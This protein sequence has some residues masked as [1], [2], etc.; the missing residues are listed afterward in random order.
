MRSS[1]AINF[2]QEE[3]PTGVVTFLFTDL[4]DSTYLWEEYPT[5]MKS[6]LA[7]H[8]TILELSVDEGK[9]K[10]VKTTGDGL[11]AV[12]HSPIDAIQA[13]VTAQKSIQTE[14]WGSTGPLRVRMAL[15]SGE[16]EFR[17]GDYY[18][19]VVNRAARIM[20]S[21]AGEQI[22]VSAATADLTGDQM[23]TGVTLLDLGEH[24]LRGLNRPE[25]LYQVLHPD[26]PAEFP[27]LKTMGT[28][29]NN[30]PVET[31]SF[32]GRETELT[33]LNQLLT[34]E[35][36]NLRLI[37]LTGPGGTGK[38]RL[39]VQSARGVLDRYQHGIWFV[40]LA[41]VVEPAQVIQ[42]IA[43]PMGVRDQGARPLEQMVTDHLRNQTVL[44]V[45]DN[46]E[47]LI[48]E[49][50]RLADLL[51]Q[52]CPELHV[53]ASSRESFGIGGEQPYRVKSL[54]LP[55]APEELTIDQLSK[56]E[57]IRLFVDRAIQ[58]N[59]GFDLNVNNA[60][61]IAQI[62]LRLDGIPLAIELA[63]ARA[64]VLSPEQIAER[65]D[66]RFRLLTGGSRTA[67]PR[68]RTLQALIDWSYDL[69]P[70]DER[71]LICRL[72]AFVNGWTLD[73]AE[74]VAGYDPLETYQVLDLLE[75]LVNKSL[76]VTEKTD[77][78]MRYS[79]L[80]SIRQYAQEKLAE[81][82]DGKTMRDRHL[83]FFLNQSL[84]A[85]KNLL[86]LNPPGDWGVRFKPEADNFRLAWAWALEEDLEKAI[87]FSS[88]FTSGWNQVLPI[89]EVLQYQQSV[90][91][92]AEIHP[93]FKDQ[94]A[95]KE[96]RL[97]LGRALLGISHI[98][99]G[100]RNL[101]LGVEY[102]ARSAVVAEEIDDLPTLAFANT[103]VKMGSSFTGGKEAI[104]E[105]LDGD[106][107]FVMQHGH[108]F[109]KAICMAWWGSANFLVTGQYPQ[110]SQEKWD[111]G[112]AMLVRSGDLWSQ[113]SLLQVA[114]DIKLFLGEVDKAK[115]MAEQV[116][117]IYTELED[118][119]AA[120]PAR[121]LLADL[122]RKEG[123]L[124]N[125]NRLYRVTITG[126]RDS[127]RPEASVR[128]MESLAYVAHA[129]VQEEE[130]DR[131]FSLLVY[132]AKI[133]GSA[134]AI[135]QIINRPVNFVDIEE[136][137]RELDEIKQELG[138]IEFE[139]AWQAGQSL[140]LDDAVLLAL[141][142]PDL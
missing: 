31:T 138:E 114:A 69:L 120:T 53:L 126:W 57:A 29:P 133:M 105:W 48:D 32:I 66:D 42:A 36:G 83:A 52:S 125:A 89:V 94:D 70:E 142:A 30:L 51:L 97:L 26:L 25:G 11:H 5:E 74:S 39:A 99:S 76:V 34:H 35:N 131:R 135:R 58:I 56:F 65:L 107:D 82:G 103:I 78:G 139:S 72:S 44:I 68:Q 17:G 124:V 100:T 43:S 88:S 9:G 62:C 108:N 75:Q 115:R 85:H 119:Y 90:F 101:R 113:G 141:E 2:N 14:E 91:T 98:A 104:Q 116:L 13:V 22:L 118:V 86:E 23:P 37:T 87:K 1:I 38:T 137:E 3:Y 41:P 92:Q 67:L 64:R 117:E 136:Y 121:S 4:E 71:T 47:H 16:A 127:G 8:D 134:D 18:G 109:H 15:H 122:A 27:P 46:C 102:A 140:D 129:L 93:L 28:I 96:N 111:K 95:P 106:F 110:E 7:R 19:S 61:E 84:D 63:A 55:P 40:E 130:K 132:A 50:A 59:P 10:I 60:Q 81:S 79:M 54:S 73:A 112:M 49:C 20:G 80:E 123:D 33:E 77:L 45:L 6:A 12:F 21:A 24:Y 128:T